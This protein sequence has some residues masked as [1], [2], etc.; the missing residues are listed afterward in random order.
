MTGYSPPRINALPHQDINYIIRNNL[1]VIMAGD[2]NA[3]HRIF[4][5]GNARNTKGIQLNNHI[6]NNRIQYIGPT[7]NTF[8]THNSETKP[9]C[10]ITNNR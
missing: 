6:Y 5:Y 2:L 9:D 8:Y 3:R 7:F 10:I 4:G 1:P